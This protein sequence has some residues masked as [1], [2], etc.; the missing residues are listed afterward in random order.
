VEKE[1]ADRSGEIFRPDRLVKG[2]DTVWIGEYKTGSRT[3]A[4]D[5]RQVS[6]YL[7]LLSQLY[8]ECEITG[9]ILYLD[10]GVAERI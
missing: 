2:Q 6:Q 4:G 8:P 9:V 10:Q 1:V 3:R 7:D 5:R